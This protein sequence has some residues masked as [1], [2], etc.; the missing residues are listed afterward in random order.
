MVFKRDI[1]K[2]WKKY[3]EILTKENFYTCM[4]IR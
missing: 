4:N 3:L 1:Y 2:G